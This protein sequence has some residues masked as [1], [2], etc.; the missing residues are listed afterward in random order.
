MKKIMFT[1]AF[2]AVTAFTHC[3]QA[4]SVEVYPKPQQIAWGSEV[5]F[6]NTTAYTLTGA[7]TADID[8]VNVFKKNF[9]IK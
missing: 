4:Q 7:E 6:A 1:I 9:N 8:A 2:L 3:L 5:A